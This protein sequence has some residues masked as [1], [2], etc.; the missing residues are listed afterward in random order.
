M[1]SDEDVLVIGKAIAN[2][3]KK[4]NEAFAVGAAQAI[5]AY[6]VKELAPLSERLAELEK[7]QAGAMNWR[8][9]FQR[10]QTYKR[11]DCATSDGGLWFCIRDVD[12]S[13]GKPGADEVAQSW[14]LTTKTR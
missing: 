8:G 11:G 4:L 7:R 14:Q 5:R 3:S 2:E 1:L 13:A 9:V 10:A 12:G 6:V